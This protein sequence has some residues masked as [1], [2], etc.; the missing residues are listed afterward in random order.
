MGRAVQ[1]HLVAAG[2]D[3][4]AQA[5]VVAHRPGRQEHRRLVAEQVGH[6][7]AQLADR[8]VEEVLLVAH[9]GRRHHAAHLLGRARLG[10][11]AQI[12]HRHGASP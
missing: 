9:L 7:L 12:D 5:D 2:A 6:P 10:V 4:Q 1:D 8:G 11:R 3:V